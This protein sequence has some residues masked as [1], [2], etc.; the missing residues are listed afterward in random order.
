MKQAVLSVA[1]DHI[2]ERNKTFLHYLNYD[3]NLWPPVQFYKIMPETV[4]AKKTEKVSKSALN[5]VYVSSPLN[6]SWQEAVQQASNL[7]PFCWQ[8]CITL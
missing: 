5:R 1:M 4:L 3:Y 6:Y 8:Y 7:C 2:V